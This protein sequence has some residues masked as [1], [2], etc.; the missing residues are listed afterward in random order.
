MAQYRTGTINMVIRTI[1]MPPKDGMAMGTMMS[2]PRP[3]EARTGTRARIVVVAVM[4]HGRTLRKP[5]S[6]V[7][8]RTS[9]MD[10]GSFFAKD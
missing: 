7:A 3:V 2:E 9:D 8:L 4:R 1:S 6:I 5:A 10:F